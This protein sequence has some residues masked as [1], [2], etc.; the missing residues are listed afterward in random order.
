MKIELRGIIQHHDGGHK[1]V[2]VV[3]TEGNPH[4]YVTHRVG[5]DIVV[6]RGKILA[7]L[8]GHY[9]IKPGDIVWPAHIML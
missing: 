5:V 8:A 7:F 2:D 9:G 4:I 1:Y 3:V 6:N